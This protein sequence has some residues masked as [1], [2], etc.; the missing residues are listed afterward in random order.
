M[1]TI[2]LS[3]LLILSLLLNAYQAFRM[4]SF[5]LFCASQVNNALKFTEKISDQLVPIV[6]GDIPHTKASTL[7][8]DIKLFLIFNKYDSVIKRQDFR[9]R[10][11]RFIKKY[12]L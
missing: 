9:R 6:N 8:N 4:F 7:R 11:P 1:L 2:T 3:A 10:H 12:E 5:G